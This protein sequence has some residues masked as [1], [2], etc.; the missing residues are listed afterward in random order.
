MSSVQE[1]CVDASLVVKVV[2]P[3]PDSDRADAL[4][5]EW[6][7]TDTLNRQRLQKQV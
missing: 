3:E 2:V 6:L 4:F 7:E 5:H 1:V